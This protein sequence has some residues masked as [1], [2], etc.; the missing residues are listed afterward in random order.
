MSQC[1]MHQITMQDRTRQTVYVDAL[2]TERRMSVGEKVPAHRTDRPRIGR[3]H[4]LRPPWTDE[5][6]VRR[7]CSSC[8]DCL[9]ACPEAILIPGPARTPVVNFAK[10]E[11]TFCGACA[12]ACPEDV[13]RETT[14]VPW[15]NVAA[16]ST[17][18]LLTAGVECRSCTDFCDRRALGFDLRA[19]PVGRIDLDPEACTGCGACV[20][21]CP[22]HSITIQPAPP[23][24]ASDEHMRMS[25]SRCA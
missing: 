6:A 1:S 20:A 18:C 13:F 15:A 24:R 21:A 14:D 10:G 19:R 12:E 11:C 9:R 8:G 4:Y 7:S 17:S 25:G 22:T 3:S 16:I 23:R 5:E 2:A